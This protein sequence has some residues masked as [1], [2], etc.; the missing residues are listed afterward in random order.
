[1]ATVA[2]PY[3]LRA[4]NR[5]DGLP[6]AGA[7]RLL[8]IASGYNTNIF[9][10]DIVS[11]AAGTLTRTTGTAALAN[12]IGVFVGC[13]YTDPNLK[14][15]VFRQYYPANTAASDIQAYVI[16]DPD[17]LFQIQA[18]ASVVAAN[19]GSNAAIVNTAGNTATGN[20]A[21]ALDA[22]TIATTATLPLRLVDFV[23]GPTS[24]PG[25]AFTDVLV[26]FNF[27]MHRYENAT[28]A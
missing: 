17:V 16:D 4:V 15:K 20:S 27:G 2:S 13:T 8:P 10:G 14:Y 26:K 5:L 23:N 25:D 12:I 11:F 19:I 28:G 7:T 3:G 22:S 9:N 24:Q 6:Y 1:M 18:S 21:I